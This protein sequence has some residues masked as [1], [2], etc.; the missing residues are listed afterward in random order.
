MKY[1]SKLYVLRIG[2]QPLEES[3]PPQV[4]CLNCADIILFYPHEIAGA[5]STRSAILNLIFSASL[6]ATSSF[7]TLDKMIYPDILVSQQ[8]LD[9]YSLIPIPALLRI[10]QVNSE[11]ISLMPSAGLMS[12]CNTTGIGYK[13]YSL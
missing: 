11:N 5:T 9:T 12:I 8:N 1:T 3:L 4:Q 2:Y 13:K 10:T 7:V 6:L